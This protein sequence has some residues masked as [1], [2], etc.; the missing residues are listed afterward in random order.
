M[1]TAVILIRVINVQIRLLCE[2]LNT[3]LRNANARDCCNNRFLHA[4]LIC[5]RTAHICKVLTIA[6]KLDPFKCLMNGS[7]SGRDTSRSKKN[8]PSLAILP[9]ILIDRTETSDSL[10]LT[11]SKIVFKMPCC[12]S[13]VKPSSLLPTYTIILITVPDG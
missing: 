3:G 12:S 10:L 2:P 7:L 8:E 9:I 5:E 13:Q 1:S 11:R 4:V 6:S